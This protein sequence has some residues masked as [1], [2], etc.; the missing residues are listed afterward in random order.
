[1]SYQFNIFIFAA[2]QKIETKYQNEDFSKM[3][4][5]RKAKVLTVV[6]DVLFASSARERIVIHFISKRIKNIC[7]NLRCFIFNTKIK[8]F[9]IIISRNIIY[10]YNEV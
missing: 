5:Q 8:K 10:N 3:S 6:E 2:L 1:M 7:T 4:R 9:F